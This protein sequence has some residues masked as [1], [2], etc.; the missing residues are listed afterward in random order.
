MELEKINDLH[1]LKFILLSFIERLNLIMGYFDVSINMG[2]I[3]AEKGWISRR[4]EHN[5]C[6]KKE[7]LKCFSQKRKKTKMYILNKRT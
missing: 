6:N 4:R 5:I 2:S 7:R 1:L 3:T